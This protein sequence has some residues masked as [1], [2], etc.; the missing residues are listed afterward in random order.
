MATHPSELAEL[1]DAGLPPI[2]GRREGESTSQ[3]DALV[4]VP[5]V[6]RAV[7]QGTIFALLGVQL[8]WLAFLAVVV[9]SIVR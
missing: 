7:A 1:V 3:I 4:E 5:P 8:A 6:G 2:G 9:I